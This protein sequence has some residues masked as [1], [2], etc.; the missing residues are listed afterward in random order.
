[1]WGKSVPD[2]KRS[3][4][5]ETKTAVCLMCS[6]NSRGQ[7]QATLSE[8]GSARWQGQKQNQAW[9]RAHGQLGALGLSEGGELLGSFEQRGL[10]LMSL[11]NRPLWLLCRGKT[12]SKDGIRKRLLLSLQATLKA[13]ARLVATEV[14]WSGWSLGIFFKVELRGFHL[15]LDVECERISSGSTTTFLVLVTGSM[16]LPSAEI[17]KFAEGPHFVGKIRS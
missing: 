15:R 10:R 12:G 14:V 16:A 6:Q 4:K 3:T 1:M 2:Q 5:C 13:S 11:L 17:G 9:L 8:W 7:K